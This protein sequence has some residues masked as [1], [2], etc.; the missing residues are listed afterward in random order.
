MVTLNGNAGCTMIWPIFSDVARL[1][2][3]KVTGHVPVAVLQV[4]IPGRRS[5]E[6]VIHSFQSSSGIALISPQAS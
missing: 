6:N 3:S 1:P 4:H 2:N 5:K